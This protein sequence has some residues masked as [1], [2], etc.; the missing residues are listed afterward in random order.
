MNQM[1]K[2]DQY[3]KG[4]RENQSWKIDP[5]DIL[6]SIENDRDQPTTSLTNKS[7]INRFQIN[8]KMYDLI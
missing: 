5:F 1:L 7:I 2:K 8:K 6:S 3:T 4:L